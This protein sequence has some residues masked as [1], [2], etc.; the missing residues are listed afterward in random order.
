M[1]FYA[2]SDDALEANIHAAEAQVDVVAGILRNAFVGV[3]LNQSA[4]QL[5][6][7]WFKV[8]QAWM[9]LGAEVIAA[10]DARYPDPPNKLKLDVWKEV[11]AFLP[12]QATK[13]QGLLGSSDKNQLVEFAKRFPAALG[14]VVAMTSG[15]VAKAA[16]GVATGLTLAAAKPFLIAA[17]AVAAAAFLLSKAGLSGSAGPIKLKAR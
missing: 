13:I 3:S 6:D 9:A 1:K 14:K 5:V 12:K 17:V 4:R 11:G 10:P 8:R 15:G 16:G 2:F 7:G